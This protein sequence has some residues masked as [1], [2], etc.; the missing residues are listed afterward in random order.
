MYLDT[1]KSLNNINQDHVCI[2]E[3]TTL[4]HIKILYKI[5]QTVILLN[6]LNEKKQVAGIF[7]TFLRLLIV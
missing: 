2:S 3:I 5:N 1:I 6:A 7:S 4:S